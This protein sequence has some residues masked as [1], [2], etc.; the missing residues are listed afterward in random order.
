MGREN[1]NN[2]NKVR[3]RCVNH[4]YRQSNTKSIQ[5]YGIDTEAYTTGECFLICTSE[6]DVWSEKDFPRCLF[7]R[8]YRGSAFVA[9]NL[10][11]DEGALLQFLPY[12]NLCELWEE[13]RTKY[14][15][16]TIRSIP[17]K[18]LSIR[19]GK[20]T[21]TFYDM[22]NFY[23]GSL[24]YNAKKYLGKT[25]EDIETKE[26][27]K[28]FVS[29]NYD[30]IKKYCIQDAILVKE[31]ADLLIKRFESF[32]IYPRKL[33]STAYVSFQYFVRKTKY[34]TV[35]RFWDEDKK[36][37]DFAMKSYNGGK[38]EVTEKGVDD[39]YE[40]DIISAYPYE[41]A[42]LIDITHSRIVWSNKYRKFAQYG[43]LHV[44][45]KIPVETY[46]PVA[47]K[48]GQ[49]N[50][51]PSGYIERV[52]TKT[53]Y[54]YLIKY[55]TDITILDAVW[56]HCDKITYPYKKEILKM[57]DLKQQF[58]AQGQE[59]DYHTIKILLNSLYGKMVQLI[60]KGEYMEASTCWNPIYA[61]VIT[62]NVRVKITEF[63]QLYSEIVAVHTD[64]LISVKPLDIKEQ[65]I[66]GDMI[67]ECKGKGVIL[68]S[69]IYQIGEKTKF[70][71][72][73][74]KK[75]LFEMLDTKKKTITFYELRPYTWKEVI[76]HK[77][78]KTNINQFNYIEK[79][80]DVNFDR[81]RL[82]LED[83][84]NFREVLQHKVESLPYFCTRVG[85]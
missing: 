63:Q 83:W 28:D 22:Y 49:V 2:I 50:T 67:F 65:G 77:W 29:T 34:V 73:L 43:F 78:D 27:T 7:S 66:L 79:K 20:N 21:C 3:Y 33:Y 75:S 31:L 71:G 84:H 57:V 1:D 68:G 82:W 30:R 42:N 39:Y 12:S 45:M 35:K 14:N 5:V 11:Y 74:T 18:M 47:I 59:L 37:L 15:E 8:K 46:S 72:F 17:R 51:Y 61:S 36:L 80:L 32:G 44:K 9:Y 38:F 52:I 58:K 64:S 19:K 41:I 40:Y 85:V 4:I 54:D 6:G 16:Y 13:G 60:D 24:E 25:K 62:A 48:Y 10:K 81:K 55:N 70:R 53:E 76:F 56:L 69:G 23:L 26:F